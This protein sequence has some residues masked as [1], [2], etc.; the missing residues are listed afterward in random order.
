M[1]TSAMTQRAPAALQVRL[2]HR[3]AAPDRNAS[4][5]SHVVVSHYTL[6]FL[7]PGD[8]ERAATFQSYLQWWPRSQLAGYLDAIDP[9]LGQ[10]RTVAPGTEPNTALEHR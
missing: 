10:H 3:S 1:R 7:D 4:P 9:G 5:G 8:R 6:D 2:G